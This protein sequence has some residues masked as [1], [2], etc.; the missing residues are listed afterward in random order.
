MPYN[1]EWL[2]ERVCRYC[3]QTFKTACTRRHYCDDR[4]WMA[5]HPSKPY[6]YPRWTH[7]EIKVLRE[8]AGK[9]L[10]C[11]IAERTGRTCKAVKHKAKVL[12][13]SLMCYGEYH[14][15]T[16]HGDAV[17]EQARTLY[18]EGKGPKDIAR[19]LGIPYG[20]AQNY[21]YYENRLG[22]PAEYYFQ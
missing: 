2:K 9:A 22:P 8:L 12:H 15:H 17:V 11:V 16:K 3:G 19:Q 20:T 21:V 7:E 6:K 14:P 10:V 5:A 4:C 1:P 18:D 13:I